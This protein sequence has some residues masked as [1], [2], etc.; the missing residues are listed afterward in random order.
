M[1]K[2]DCI[3]C[4]I[5][6]GEIPSAT[7]YEDDTIKAFLD[8]APA[9][10]GH[11]L[12]ITKEHYDNIFRLDKETAGKVFAFATDLAKAV[13]KETNCPGM[14]VVQNNGQVAGQTVNHFHLHLIPRFPEDEVKVTWKQ[15]DTVP[16]EQNALAEEIRKGL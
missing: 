14:N 1:K 13:K 10:K 16:E 12:I 2:D 5:A 11:A 4:K 6:S 3:F 8:V 15:G 9:G 7:I